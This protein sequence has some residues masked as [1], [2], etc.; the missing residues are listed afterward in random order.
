MYPHWYKNILD[1]NYPN[2]VGDIQSGRI[3][4]GIIKGFGWMKE[5][6]IHRPWVTTWA[7]IKEMSFLC[8]NCTCGWSL[9]K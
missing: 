5:T 7:I 1:I 2:P 4:K 9:M 8:T 6:K 3:I